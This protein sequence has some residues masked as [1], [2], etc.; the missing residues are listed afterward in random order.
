MMLN[1]RVVFVSDANATR[2]D[3]E[4][5]ATLA[6]ILQVFGDVLSTDET[7]ARLGSASSAAAAS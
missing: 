7:I 2:T 4:H 6:S 3:E 1:Y 5:I